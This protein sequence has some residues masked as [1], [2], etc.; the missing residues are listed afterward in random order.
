MN[1][2]T[3]YEYETLHHTNNHPS[4]SDVTNSLCTWHLAGTTVFRSKFFQIPW[5]SFPNS[6][7]HRG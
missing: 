2:N 1:I 7:A 6:V 4:I 5:A 3:F